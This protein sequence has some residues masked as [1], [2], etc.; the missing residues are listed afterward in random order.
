M[1]FPASAAA[2]AP[3][4]APVP[5]S[6]SASDESLGPS[7]PADERPASSSSQEARQKKQKQKKPKR[8]PAGHGPLG[9]SAPGAGEGERPPESRV[10]SFKGALT[11]SLLGA[12]AVFFRAPVRLYRPVKISALSV[13]DSLAQ[14]EGTTLSFKFLRTLWKRE[15]TAFFAHVLGPPLLINTAIGFTLFEAFS[16]TERSLLRRYTPPRRTLRDSAGRLIPHWSPL[17]IVTVSGG[18]AGAAQCLISAPLDNVRKVLSH[19]PALAHPRHA[20]SPRPFSWTA[21]LRAAILPFAP[22]EHQHQRMMGKVNQSLTQSAPQSDASV[23]VSVS[24]S[25]KG[26]APKPSVTKSSRWNQYLSAWRGGAHGA[27]LV[28]SMTRDSIGF[29]SFFA[30]FEVSRRVAYHASIAVDMVYYTFNKSPTLLPGAQGGGNVPRSATPSGSTGDV[31]VF[32]VSSKTDNVDESETKND[33]SF[34]A[35]RSLLGRTVAAVTLIA[36]GALGAATYELLGRPAELMRT[37]L[38]E[39]ER[40]WHQ[41][42]RPQAQR[43]AFRPR[44][45]S[46]VGEPGKATHTQQP[47]RVRRAVCPTLPIPPRVSGTHVRSVGQRRAALASLRIS[48][49]PG[50]SAPR[51]TTTPA[52]TAMTAVTPEQKRQPRAKARRERVRSSYE[53]LTRQ[54]KP[55]AWSMLRDHAILHWRRHNPRGQRPPTL[56]L[57]FQTY[58]LQPFGLNTFF[59]LGLFPHAKRPSAAVV[60]G[61]SPE[62]ALRHRWTIRNSVNPSVV[63]S[64]KLVPRVGSYWSRATWWILRRVATPY[65]A[66]LAAFAIFGGDLAT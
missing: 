10:D 53:H 18:V 44:R 56:P 26:I 3:A 39:S 25:G 22:T 62:N 42:V 1:A 23:S 34:Q 24:G 9:A 12:I 46:A 15:R 55:S 16:L 2:P 14:R 31:H 36:G 45:S 30:V 50:S 54:R 5:A 51:V 19:P 33:Y 40:L 37:V 49:T 63:G 11:R 13:L 41:S 61:G 38:F 43:S 20:R 17:W 29:A 52:G 48:S 28:L 21:I 7:S 66:G 65:G 32:D 4:T 35:S 47:R 58:F 27:G 8:R 64:E 60:A 57:M 6:A 59:S